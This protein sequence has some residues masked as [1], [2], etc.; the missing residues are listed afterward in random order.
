M[1]KRYQRVI[2]E[3]F[4]VTDVVVVIGAWLLSYWAR[5]YLPSLP[6]AKE[7]PPFQEY[8]VLVPLVAVLWMAVFSFA[9]V[10]ES[11]RLRSRPA[12][13]LLLWKAHAIALSAFVALTFAYDRYRYSRLVMIYFAIIGAVLLALF[14]FS[15]RTGLRSIRKRGFN[16]RHVLVV[17]SGPSLEQLVRRFARYPELGYRVA[18][19]VAEARP[20]AE[21]ALDGLPLLGNYDNLTEVIQRTGVDE[22]ILALPR[23]Q[24]QRLGSLLASIQD[25]VQDVRVLP[26]VFDFV[27]FGCDVEQL[28]GLPIVR[29]N[30][31]PMDGWGALLKRVMDILFASLALCL[32]APLLLVIAA[33]VKLTSPG[34]V[35]YRQER[36][37]L[38]GRSFE[39]LK[40]RSM[41]SDAEVSSGATW[42][43]A[44]DDRRT[45][46]GAFLRSTSLDEL[47]QFWNV[48]VGD[49]SLVGPRPERPVFV[50]QFRHEIPHYM[51]RHKVKAGITGWAQIN[52]WRGN[53]SLAHRIEFD[54]FY[55]RHWSLLLD[56]KILA[57]T[58]FKGFVHKNAY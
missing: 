8:Q 12:E 13:I 35:L 27:T 6:I 7:L 22:V 48:L 4:R 14:R 3:L 5:F 16:L 17:G 40:F 18:G 50:Q 19:L 33:L 28:D 9:G 41:R 21:S 39:M 46:F 37:G 51:L 47:P 42:A 55:I 15:L 25:E 54:L 57:M 1:I 49:M 23:E 34:P 38:D 26:D 45:A 58:V 11:G 43:R 2:G 53:T 20:P 24:Q 30:D 56:M 10:Y 31:S 36:M 32:L 52:G 29:L 44:N